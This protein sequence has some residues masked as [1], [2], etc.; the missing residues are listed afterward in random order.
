MRVFCLVD[1]IVLRPHLQLDP[2][3]EL[4]GQVSLTDTGPKVQDIHKFDDDMQDF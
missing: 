1:P 2:L 3:E 4:R